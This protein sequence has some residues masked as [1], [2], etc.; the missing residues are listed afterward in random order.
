MSG[1]VILVDEQDNPLG[2]EEK[3]IAHQQ[4][5]LHR[6]FSIFLFRQYQ[7][8]IEVL[9]QQRHINKYHGGGLWTN[10]CCSHP[11]P[12]ESILEAARRRLQE[13]LG[14]TTN[15]VEVG[16]FVYKAEVGNGLVEHEFDHVCIGVL[17]KNIINIPYNPQEIQHLRWMTLDEVRVDYHA[18]LEQYT[19]WFEQ[20][21]DIAV[22]NHHFVSLFK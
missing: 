12:G 18:H 16:S 15:L 2:V 21:L 14:I 6:A 3:L 22:N 5:M 9:M 11:Q 8:Q 10:T 7:H 13:E 17:D 4:A 1:K 19:P 20:A